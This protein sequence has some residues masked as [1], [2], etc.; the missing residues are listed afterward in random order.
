M[1]VIIINVKYFKEFYLE[2]DFLQMDKKNPNL[3]NN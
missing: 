3:F 2:I 1:I